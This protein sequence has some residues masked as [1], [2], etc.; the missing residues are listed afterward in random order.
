[1]DITDKINRIL[2]EKE[3][4]KKKKA[5]VKGN[6]MRKIEAEGRRSKKWQTYDT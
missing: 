6:K 5:R 4:P 2:S 1:M 3:D